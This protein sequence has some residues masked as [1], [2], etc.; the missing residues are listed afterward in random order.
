[1]RRA[2]SLLELMVVLAIV[3]VLVA[4]ALPKFGSSSCRAAETEAKALLRGVAT[5]QAESWAKNG[6]Y[7]DVKTSCPT[8]KAGVVGTPCIVASAK[9][10]ITYKVTGTGSGNK[11]T[12][13]A[14]GVAGTRSAGSVW[15][16]DETGALTDVAQI[17]RNAP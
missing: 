11:Y 2:F 4:L 16:L 15:K 13:T 12:V 1:M 5:E 14:V 3:G 9:G 6:R 17:C 8:P 10:P 7:A